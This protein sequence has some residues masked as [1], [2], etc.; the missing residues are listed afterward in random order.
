MNLSEAERKR[1]RA[2]VNGEDWARVGTSAA[3]EVESGSG[4]ASPESEETAL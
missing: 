4:V 1:L 2:L 3:E